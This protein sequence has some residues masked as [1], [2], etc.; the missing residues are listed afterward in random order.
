[1]PIGKNLGY[2]S[3]VEKNL[4]ESLRELPHPLSSVKFLRTSM[5]KHFTFVES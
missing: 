3:I 1:M 5:G 4:G 2:F